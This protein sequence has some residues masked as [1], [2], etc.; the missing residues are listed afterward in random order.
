MSKTIVIEKLNQMPESLMGIISTMLDNLLEGYE[1]GR[2]ITDDEFTEAEL[3]E[4]DRRYEEMLTK[5]DAS[6]SLEEVLKYMH[7]THGL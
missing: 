4:L 1:I 7:Q 5:P 2:H 6:Y 3:N